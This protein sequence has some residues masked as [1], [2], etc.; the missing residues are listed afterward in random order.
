MRLG[1]NPNDIPLWQAA[2]Y[3]KY[4]DEFTPDQTTNH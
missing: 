3:V 4:R 2:E 1:L